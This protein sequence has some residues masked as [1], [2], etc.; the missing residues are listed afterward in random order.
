MNQPTVPVVALC[1]NRLDALGMWCLMSIFMSFVNSHF[2]EVVLYLYVQS[3]AL[4][5]V[6]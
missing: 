3:F 6:H 4:L 2:I 5:V 1:Q